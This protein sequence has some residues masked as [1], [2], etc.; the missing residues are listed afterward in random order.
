[1]LS[2]TPTPPPGSLSAA[3]AAERAIVTVEKA[4]F[5]RDPARLFERSRQGEVVVVVDENG[6]HLGTL[7]HPHITD[8]EF[9]RIHR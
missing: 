8:E 1:M 3:P 2:G 6:N 7:S 4:E 5:L 9:N